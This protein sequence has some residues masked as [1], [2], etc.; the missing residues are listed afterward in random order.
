MFNVCPGCGEYSD[1]KEVDPA[2]PFA[3]CPS[4]GHRER[5][6]RLPL[7]VVTGASGTG[8]SSVAL[9]L[10]PA[11]RDYVCLDGDILWRPELDDPDD[12]YQAFRTLLLR[13]AKSIAQAGRPVVLMAGGS[14]EQFEASPERRYFTT[15]HYL[16]LVCDDSVL[17]SRLTARPAWRHSAG[18]AVLDRERSFNRWLR[19]NASKTVPPMTVVDTSAI[20]DRDAAR[21]VAAWVADERTRV[22]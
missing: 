22:G 14:P 10:A 13:V 21:R 7:F 3:I 18:H 6:V 11:L 5:F 9:R 2:G 12:G 1:E 17:V 16:A 19:E 4:C 15:L 20:S 8:K